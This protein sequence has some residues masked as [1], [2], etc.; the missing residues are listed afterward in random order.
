M[1]AYQLALHQLREQ[2]ILAVEAV[3]LFHKTYLQVFLLRQRV[4]QA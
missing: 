1:V 2:P 4:D 3:L